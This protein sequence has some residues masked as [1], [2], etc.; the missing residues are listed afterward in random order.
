MLYPHSK[1][2]QGGASGQG[3]TTR[4]SSQAAASPQSSVI[5]SAGKAESRALGRPQ[6]RSEQE[7]T[8][9]AEDSLDS[10]FRAARPPWLSRPRLAANVIMVRTTFSFAWSIPQSRRWLG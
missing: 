10:P 6:S 8:E 4:L 3:N 5:N 7:G 1:A 9:E 2:F